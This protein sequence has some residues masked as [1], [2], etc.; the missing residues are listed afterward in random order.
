MKVKDLKKHLQHLTSFRTNEV[1]ITTMLILVPGKIYTGNF[2]S[3]YLVDFNHDV[4]GAIDFAKFKKIIMNLDPN[5]VVGFKDDP[6]RE[7]VFIKINNIVQFKFPRQDPKDFI[8]YPQIEENSMVVS[9]GKFTLQDLTIL[10]EALGF[11]SKDKLRPAMN[12]VFVTEKKMVATD[13]NRMFFDTHSGFGFS[14]I[15]K[16]I[17]ELDS[18]LLQQAGKEQHELSNEEYHAFTKI[19]KKPITGVI[20]EKLVC[21]AMVKQKE[22]LSLRLFTVNP[23][24][25]DPKTEE[26]YIT[27]E[28]IAEISGEGFQIISKEIDER[29]PDYWNV[30]PDYEKVNHLE[31]LTNTNNLLKNVKLAEISSNPSTHKIVFEFGQDHDPGFRISS[32]DLDLSVEFKRDMPGIKSS[33]HLEK[34]V[35]RVSAEGELVE[36]EIGPEKWFDA[37][38]FNALFLLSILKNIKSDYTVM[39]FQ[40]PGRAAVINGRYLIMPVM[41]DPKNY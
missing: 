40:A 1:E 2:T 28:L 25:I 38:G 23:E 11:V 39:Q 3:R 16:G 7:V 34:T 27:S 30:I 33:I 17:T 20:L 5:D 19:T 37:I 35:Q 18:E 21:H 12:G 22:A 6:E 9:P 14:R 15:A 32:E 41:L 26:G 4:T 36:R 8:K 10:E 29:F 24:R 31:L 13:G